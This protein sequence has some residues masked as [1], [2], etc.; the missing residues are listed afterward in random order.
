MQSSLAQVNM[1]SQNR[2]SAPAW[3]EREVLDLIT[4]WGDESMISELCSKRRN[5]GIFGKK[6]ISKGMKDRSYNRDLQRCHVKLK[7]LRQAYQRTREANGC[8]GS[9]P[10]I[11]HFCD[12][13]HAIIEGAP[14]TTPPLCVDSVNGFS[15][16][17][18]ANFGDE[19]DNEEE[20]EDN[21]QQASRESIFPNS[22][23]LFFTLDLVPSQPTQGGDG[24]R[25]VHIDNNPEYFASLT[26]KERLE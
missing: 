7:K 10:Q 22:Q 23:E 26:L 17:R 25:S 8:S 13:L 12:E 14:I 2:R 20:V 6:K 4:V 1:E 18:D 16:N 15:C 5:A 24:D 19:E 11:C 21:A 3:T 9:E